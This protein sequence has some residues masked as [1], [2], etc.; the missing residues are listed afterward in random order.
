MDH[1]S[2]WKQR[3]RKLKQQFYE[4][5]E[6][7]QDKQKNFPNPNSSNIFNSFEF[8]EAIASQGFT[9]SLTDW[10]THSVNQ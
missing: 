7:M 5:Y 10:L 6:D 8:L 4:F 3:S 2:T 1:F 9:F